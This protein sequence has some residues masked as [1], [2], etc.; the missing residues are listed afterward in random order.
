M[1]YF[2]AFGARTSVVEMFGIFPALFSPMP[3][4]DPERWKELCTLASKER[5]PDKLLELTKEII[6][7][8]DAK[9]ER[10][11]LDLEA[12]QKVAS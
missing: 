3:D 10:I 2:G 6:R 9:H 8:L 1:A 5:D 12:E 11:K 7:L 4:Q